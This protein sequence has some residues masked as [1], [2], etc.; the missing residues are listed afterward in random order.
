MREGPLDIQELDQCIAFLCDSPSD[1]RA[2]ALV[3]RSWTS[4]AQIHIFRELS[5]RSASS[6]RLWEKTE[7]LFRNSP[8]LIC[9]IQRL[10]L[11]WDALPRDTFSAVC[12]FPF[13]HLRDVCV[14]QNA[15]VTLLEAAAIQT[16]FSLP[17][18][19]RVKI[20]A[21]LLEPSSFLQIWD[22]ITPNVIHLDLS[23]SNDFPEEIRRRPIPNR[24]SPPIAPK[25]L[26]IRT[27]DYVRNW[28]VDE[29][30]PL[31]YSR[32]KVLSLLY[33]YEELSR[34]SKFAPALQ[35]VEVLDLL[36]DDATNIIDLSVLP[37]LVR[38]RITLYK[39]AAVERALR[40]LSTLAASSHIQTM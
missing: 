22:A 21:T 15:G 23:C 10:V 36:V 26:R 4:A 33:G 28:V 38:L 1:L 30:S 34:L 20:D 8:H 32:V 17:T 3:A 37:S 9:H 7:Q 31:D 24:R 16:L 29:L 12:K 39:P 5:I 25:I 11:H 18:L 35:T 13:T 40:I 14:C 6:N 27:M 2:C 19:R